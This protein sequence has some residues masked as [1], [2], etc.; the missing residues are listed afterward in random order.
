MSTASDDLLSEA[1]R[2][3]KVSIGLPVRNGARYLE[4]SLDALL[5]QSFTDF[6]LIISDNASTDST[7]AICKSYAARDPR[8][9]FLRQ[10]DNIGSAANHNEVFRRA[11]GKYF[12]WA[13]DDDLYDPDLIRR[14]VEILETRSEVVV[15][16]CW[17]AVIDE[18][19]QIID[20]PE[21]VL[22]TAS[23]DPVARLRSLL[24]VSGGNDIYGVIRTGVMRRTHLHGS[25]HNADRTFVAELALY[26]PFQQVPDVLYYRRDHAARTSRRNTGVRSRAAILDPARA[27]RLRHP[28]VRIGAEYVAGYLAAIWRAP[29]TPVER[30]RCTVQVTMW[31]VSRVSPGPLRRRMEDGFTG[32][33]T[34]EK[35]K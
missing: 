20:R 19:G 22:D 8:I 1:D 9:R 4:Q 34:P 15:A 2:A 12:K 33:G 35:G 16:H 27:S 30:A 21:Y 11:R 23:S 7:T 29:L 26:G 6:E 14:C 17:D 5:A 10:A 3:P 31:V 18:T 25:Y 32:G 13:S 28:M 24:F